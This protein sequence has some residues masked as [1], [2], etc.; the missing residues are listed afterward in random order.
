[1][2]RSTI[3]SISIDTIRR[4]VD[5]QSFAR[6]HDY[7]ASGYIFGGS[8]SQDKSGR[9]TIRAQSGGQS[10]GPYWVSALVHSQKIISAQC[11]C[12]IGIESDGHCKHVA[13]M[14]LH[15]LEQP[16]EF[17]EVE[18]LSTVLDCL[19]KP[20]LIKLIENLLAHA[21]QLVRHVVGEMPKAQGGVDNANQAPNPKPSQLQV[22]AIFNSSRLW[23]HRDI[24]SVDGELRRIVDKASTR[25]NNGDWIGAVEIHIGVLHA[26]MPILHQF[27]ENWDY[28]LMHIRQCVASLQ[29][30][31]QLVTAP[32]KLRSAI[33]D[34]LVFTIRTDINVLGGLGASEGAADILANDA[35]L[36]ERLAIAQTLWADIDQANAETRKD[37]TRSHSHWSQ[38]KLGMIVLKLVGN[39]LKDSDYLKLCRNAHLL[40]PAIQFMLQRGRIAEAEDM[41]K[42]ASDYELVGLAGTF[43]SN[44]NADSA[45]K[46]MLPRA[47]TS[48][49]SRIAV[50]LRDHFAEVGQIAEAYQWAK[51]V[52]SLHPTLEDYR[53]LKALWTTPN[54]WPDERESVL[55]TIKTAR[56]ESV[57]IDILLE[58]QLYDEAIAF[59]EAPKTDRVR[60]SY[61]VAQAVE[62]T[63]PKDA[64]R[65]YAPVV[66]AH[67]AERK[68]PSYT[69]A[70]TLLVHMRTLYHR[71]Q[72]DSDW[73]IY[74]LQIQET[75]RRLPALAQE[76]AKRAI[77]L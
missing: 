72:Q 51:Q 44:G 22:E 63:R 27:D 14:L 15:W 54:N 74:L 19:T 21:P 28:P 64:I 48:T 61:H 8:H 77:D 60:G 71:L 58:E 29:D 76:L 30:G 26:L 62:N 7:A 34:A 17:V 73:A 47:R 12:P 18:D 39:Q 36:E 66:T 2:P 4:F 33:L 1:M 49:D 13:A 70:V 11:D 40:A 43:K 24:H 75:A 31:L 50:W 35:T 37:T 10:G 65:L 55:T 20:E 9:H 53:H 16:N 56:W 46:L 59:V 5:D 23:S 67:I 52:I 38:G 3:A 69:E 68:R 6:A 32:S 57:Y 25:A 45:V 42:T 41:A